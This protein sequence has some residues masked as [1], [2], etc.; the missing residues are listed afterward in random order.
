MVQGAL[1]LVTVQAG[2]PTTEPDLTSLN[3][4]T[5]EPGGGWVEKC[6][7]TKLCYLKHK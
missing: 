6:V 7:D 4:A 3:L 1:Q 2:S 5:G